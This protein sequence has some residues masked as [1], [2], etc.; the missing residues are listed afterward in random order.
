M[1]MGACKRGFPLKRAIYTTRYKKATLYG[2]FF[3][4]RNMRV[5]RTYEEV[6]LT[7]NI[8][9]AEE[10][11]CRKADVTQQLKRQRRVIL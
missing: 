5:I 4:G 11:R 8:R 6:G 9:R 2:W 1:T 7:R 10:R 3:I